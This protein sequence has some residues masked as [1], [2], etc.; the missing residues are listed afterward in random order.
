MFLMREFNRQYNLETQ[1]G[2]SQPVGYS[3]SYTSALRPDHIY[4]QIRTTKIKTI[5]QLHRLY[6]VMASTSDSDQIC[7]C[8][9]W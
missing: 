7:L 6:S 3:R 1:L 2:R 8:P 4:I 5:Q 9:F